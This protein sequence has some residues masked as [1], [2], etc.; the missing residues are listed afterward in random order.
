MLIPILKSICICVG[1]IIYLLNKEEKNRCVLRSVVAVLRLTTFP[2]ITTQTL[3]IE[4][5]VSHSTIMFNKTCCVV[6]CF[7]E[8]LFSFYTVELCLM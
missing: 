7:K 2:F 1:E 8:E 6:P 4:I 5:C 3:Q